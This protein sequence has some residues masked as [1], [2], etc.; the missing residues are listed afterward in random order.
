MNRIRASCQVA[1][2]L[3]GKRSW[4]QA[5][6]MGIPPATLSHWV[7]G[8]YA[9]TIRNRLMLSEYYGLHPDEFLGEADEAFV[10]RLHELYKEPA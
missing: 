10:A 9:P 7:S 1:R 6:E 2:Q 8:R 4:E 3:T 5:Q